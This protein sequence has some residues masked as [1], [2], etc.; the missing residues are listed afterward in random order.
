MAELVLFLHLF[1]IL[2]FITGF[3]VGLVINHRG[4]RY[5]HSAAL[6][7]VTLLMILG[8]PCPLTVWEETLRQDSY[9]GSFIAGWLQRIV[10]MEW[11]EPGHVLIADIFFS[12]LV[13]TS[14]LWR[15][16]KK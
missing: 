3:A 7:I 16:L 8:I 12:I 2:F 10:Y 15:P 5:F 1:V 9:G 6:A 4:F 14:F 13:F 11:F